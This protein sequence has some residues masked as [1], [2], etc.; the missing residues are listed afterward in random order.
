M[1]LGAIDI[2]NGQIYFRSNNTFGPLPTAVSAVSGTGTTINLGGGGVYTYLFASYAG[3]GAEIWYVGDLHGVLTIPAI[4]NLCRLTQW[5]L[6][7]P[8]GAGVPDG[9]ITVML[10]GLALG[11]LGIARRYITS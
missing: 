5:T 11:A 7:G 6:F 2:A 9:G 8:A 10:L 4:F 1:A 3:L